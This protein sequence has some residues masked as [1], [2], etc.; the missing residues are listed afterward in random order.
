MGDKNSSIEVDEGKGRKTEQQDATGLPLLSPNVNKKKSTGKRRRSWVWDH[1]NEVEKKNATDSCSTKCNYCETS[2][3]SDPKLNGTTSMSHHLEHQCSKYLY[4]KAERGQST[5]GFKPKTEGDPTSSL[6]PDSFSPDRC[7]QA[8]VEMLI[9]DE[10]PFRFVEGEGFRKYMFVTCPKWTKFPSRV[11]IAK[12]CYKVYLK[13]KKLLKNVLEGNR[14][15]L[16]LTH[17]RLCII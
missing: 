15:V 9:T 13:E 17:G 14:F 6:L 4:Q 12:D 11:I 8:L 5:L 10:L 16:L 2:Y 3:A 7:R 1:F